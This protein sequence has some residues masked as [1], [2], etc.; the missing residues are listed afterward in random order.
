MKKLIYFGDPMCSWCYGFM[1]EISK[2][3]ENYQSKIEISLVMGGLYTGMKTIQDARRIGFLKQ[4][5]PKIA[6]ISGQ[7]FN[8]SLLES[9]GWVYD[10]ELSCTAVVAMRRLEPEL[11]LDIFHTIQ[12]NFYVHGM[13]SQS[14]ATFVQAAE[15]LN[16]DGE[17]FHNEIES[18]ACVAETL[19]DFQLSKTIGVSGF[20]TLILQNEEGL[21]AL[22]SGFQR[23]DILEKNLKHWLE[24]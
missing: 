1:P 12:K 14:V 6:E 11:T 15:S 22:S 17:R 16:I 19:G 3:K 20:P 24:A 2:I 18:E 7:E 13:D 5:W 10:T 21:T 4:T 9:E 23:Y 8:F